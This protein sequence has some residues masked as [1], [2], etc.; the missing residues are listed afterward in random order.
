MPH[1]GSTGH[2]G[3]VDDFAPNYEIRFGNLEHVSD[4]RGDLVLTG[5]LAPSELTYSPGTMTSGQK[6]LL[7]KEASSDAA[8]IESLDPIP[9]PELDDPNSRATLV[10]PRIDR[11]RINPEDAK[12]WIRLI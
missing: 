12:I 8:P 5:I 3:R 1:A 9:P 4:S 10:A 6:A 2:L 11:L 7:S